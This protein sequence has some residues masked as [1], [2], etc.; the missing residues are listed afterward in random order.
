[1]RARSSLGKDTATMTRR[2]VCH[3]PRAAGRFRTRWRRSMVGDIWPSR[4]TPG[5]PPAEL[6]P[7]RELLQLVACSPNTRIGIH[8]PS[9]GQRRASASR[10]P[11]CGRGPVSTSPCRRSRSVRAGII[12]S[13]SSSGSP[14]A[15]HICVRTIF[16]RGTS[17]IACSDGLDVSWDG[18]INEIL[19]A[20]ARM[21]GAVVI[22][23]P[24][25]KGRRRRDGHRATC[26]ALRI[27]RQ[28]VDFDSVSEISPRD[29]MRQHDGRRR[30]L[31]GG[32]AEHPSS[33]SYR[34]AGRLPLCNAIFG[35]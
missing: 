29:S 2:T 24:T 4:C 22:P 13:S 33:S 28:A 30:S 21:P 18:N 26:R 20:G 25:R 1:M 14:S 7:A 34:P 8:R 32:Q 5:V 19:T 23:C 27:L 3:P 10:A 11:R 31:S 17:P 6:P 35:P 12:N 9:Q 16:S 15:C